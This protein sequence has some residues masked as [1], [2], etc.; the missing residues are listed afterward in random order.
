MDFSSHQQYPADPATVYHMLTN[1]QWLGQVAEASG[2]TSHQAHSQD[3]KVLVTASLPA[4]DKVRK[5]TGTQFTVHQD[6][7]WADPSPDGSRTGTLEVTVEGMPAVLSARADLRPGG[8]G[9][10]VDFVGD[11]KV[12]IPIFGKKLEESALPYVQQV[13][14]RQQ[15]V[16]QEWLAA[17]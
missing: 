17:G 16:G 6:I 8:P 11:F 2:A 13:L 15:Q 5:F 1:E 10:L 4:P 14:D 7:R 9:T 12:N 3:G